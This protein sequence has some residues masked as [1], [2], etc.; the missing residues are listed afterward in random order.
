MRLPI[1][2]TLLLLTL[3][4]QAAAHSSALGA[5][6]IGHAWA[7]ATAP[8]GT[9][10]SVYIPFLNTGKASDTLSSA[11][12]PLAAMVMLH[13]TSTAHDI[14][15]MHMLDALELAPGKPVAMRP[16]GKHFMLTGLKRQLK[17]GDTFPMTLHFAK[18][19]KIE[20]QVMVH[21]PGAKSPTH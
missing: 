15:S 13:E 4:T 19:G 16:G 11:E 7:R 21:A 18:A 8:H 9:V 1:A 14:T 20:I 3:A 6:E 10:A 5:I 12:T 2:L 17:E